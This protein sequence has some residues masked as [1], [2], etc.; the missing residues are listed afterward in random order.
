MTVASDRLLRLRDVRDRVGLS[1]SE[2]YRRMKRGTFPKQYLI[3]SM[4]RWSA[5]EIDRWI[6]ERK[7]A[8]RRTA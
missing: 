3:D 5:Q 7:A 6:E 2:I 4:S 8:G 1:T